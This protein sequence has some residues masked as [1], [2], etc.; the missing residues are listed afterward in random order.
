M[1]R[2]GEGFRFSDLLGVSRGLSLSIA[3]WTCVNLDCDVRKAD[4]LRDSRFVVVRCFGFLSHNS[5]DNSVYI[6]ADRPKVQVRNL[7]VLV[8]FDTF[9]DFAPDAL[10]TLPVEQDL[11]GSAK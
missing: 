4:T 9:P 5:Y 2:I 3:R 1:K 6:W 8:L 7:A 11:A 10:W